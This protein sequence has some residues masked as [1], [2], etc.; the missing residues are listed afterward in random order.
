[1]AVTGKAESWK[2]YRDELERQG[3][4]LLRALPAIAK[5]AAEV[6]S[7]LDLSPRA[8]L[9]L[10]GSGD[11]YI[12]SLSCQFAYGELAGLAAR[13]VEAFDV[14]P[15]YAPLLGP[16]ALLIT[17]S[18]SGRTRSVLSGL[19]ASM[20]RGVRSLLITN[21]PDS[22]ATELA[23][24]IIHLDLPSI[25]TSGFI[26]S[27]MSYMGGMVAQ[28]CLAM[29]MAGRLGTMAG[30]HLDSYRAGLERALGSVDALLE[31]L[32]APVREF[33]ARLHGR[34][35]CLVGGGPNY[36]SAFFG[37][38]KIIESAMLPVTVQHVEEWAH[39]HRFLTGP[40]TPSVFLAMP[41]RN[42]AR[43]LEIMHAARALNS[44]IITVA[45]VEDAEIA[46]LADE[47]WPVPA[48]VQEPLQPFVCAVP[49]E[50]LAYWCMVQEDVRPFHADTRQIE[51]GLT[52]PVGQ[53]GIS[54]P[55]GG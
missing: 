22:P 6:A 41:G 5:Q 44:E 30:D 49:L 45:G 31:G 28:H 25:D 3:A 18:I 47:V 51:M 17:T 16:E 19:R 13:H 36:G 48:P 4:A 29:S 39:I 12:A 54:G 8:Q 10:S 26:P 23:T 35:L 11:S 2:V 52:M 24:D 34:T 50:L 1:M 43:M 40:D 9:Y 14:A 38:A 15:Y 33:A 53:A 55:L 42:R 32:D 20:E 37:A 27:T 7:R 21:V 46:S